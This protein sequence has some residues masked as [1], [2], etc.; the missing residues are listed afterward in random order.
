VTNSNVLAPGGR[1]EVTAASA[2]DGG[3]EVTMHLHR[4]Y[5]RGFKHVTPNLKMW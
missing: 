3:S 1:F 4:T 2:P 5:K